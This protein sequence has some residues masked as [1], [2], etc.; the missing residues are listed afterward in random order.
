MNEPSPPQ[1]PKPPEKPAW[2]R[3]SAPVGDVAAMSANA[4]APSASKGKPKVAARRP[5]SKLAINVPQ[6]FLTLKSE[7][8]VAADQPSFGERLRHE[9]STNRDGLLT[10]IVLHGGLLI[11][12]ALYALPSGGKGRPAILDVGWTAAPSAK[13]LAATTQ[14]VKIDTQLAPVKTAT[15][16][17]E[18]KVK[19][20]EPSSDDVK[21]G[22]GENS[23]KPVE[24]GGSLSARTGNGRAVIW[25][26]LK[27]DQK[28]ERGIGAGLAWLVRQQEKGGNWKLHEGYPDPGETTIRTDAGATALALLAFLGDGHTPSEG[29][30]AKAV[31]KG[32]AFLKSIQKTDGDYHDH[33]ELGRQTAFYAHS[34]ATIAMCE[35]YALTNDPSLKTS[36]ERAVKFLLNSQ[37]PKDGGW[38][39][40]PQTGESM[41]DL[42]VTGWALMALHTARIAKL[43]V[44]MDNFERAALF[45]ESVSEQG[46]SRY[47]YQ[48][49]DPSE[50][51]SA[52]MTAEGLLCRQWLGWPK[53]H[54]PQNDALSFLLSDDNR[55]TWA[56]GRRNVYAWYYTANAL[57][58]V[59]G[60]NWEAWYQHTSQLILQNQIAGSGEVG[61]SWHPNKPPGS[62]EEYASKAG[63]L[64]M[65][66]LC[67][68]VLES[69]IRHAPIYDPKKTQ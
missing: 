68:L 33:Q 26:D 40:Q 56:P 1:K 27:I 65:T 5:T 38:R 36:C 11:L 19:P 61:G 50:K 55:P 10:S 4:T 12:F 60:P 29:T 44:P 34:Q 42:S 32:V 39:Y 69:P 35:A 9:W 22:P 20:K 17:S 48:P 49:N 13:D 51:V 6:F 67:L 18:V 66:A 45:L 63:R 46:G 7:G 15:S 2:F 37:H 62:N 58:N 57:H 59:G 31:A 53:D 47:K 64:Y 3:Q 24:V 8:S 41:G 52:A 43:N 30:H 28:S 25:Q 16:L 21:P 54:P 23:A 14:P